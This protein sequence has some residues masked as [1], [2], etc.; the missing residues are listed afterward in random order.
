MK[1]YFSTFTSGTQEIIKELLYKRK[2]KIKLLL[3]GLVVYESD[4]LEREI[5]N[6]HFFNNTF[7]LLYHFNALES[8]KESLEKMLFTVINS[9]NLQYKIKSSIPLRRRNFKIVTSLENQTIAVNRELLKKLELIIIQI[10]DTRLN[11]REPNLEFWALLR[12]EKCGFFGVRI[13]YPYHGEIDRKKGE[14]KKEISYIMSV[15]SN[16]TPKDVVLDPFAGYGAIPFNRAQNFPYQ[17]IVAI[18]NN[19]RLVLKLKQVIKVIKKN[20]SVLYGDAL[21]MHKIKNNS[22]DKII[23]DPPW[24][25]YKEMFD[26]KTFYGN[27]LQEFNR[28]LKSNG[29]IVIIISAKDIFESVLQDKFKCI[30]KLKNKY[31]ILVSGKKAAIY[32]LIKAG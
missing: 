31:D 8:D 1:T 32:Q 3:D 17:E 13:T 29:I 14:L 24:G 10:G 16:P 11:I 28:V 7:I 15:I 12:R 23:T 22:I 9:R 5:R 2:I 20:I 21:D 6:F 4:Y 19:E 18:E 27:M 25:E 30:F 26:L